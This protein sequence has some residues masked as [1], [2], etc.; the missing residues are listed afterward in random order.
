[1]MY[2]PHPSMMQEPTPVW[3]NPVV[4][5]ITVVGLLAVGTFGV[6]MGMMAAKRRTAE[7]GVEASTVNKGGLIFLTDMA[8]ARAV[9]QRDGKPIY[10]QFS[11]SWCPPCK[12]MV[13]KT[14]PDAGVQDALSGYVRLYVDI[15][16][17]R[18]LAGAYNISGV[19]TM[20]VLD[21]NGKEQKRMSG[22]LPPDMLI[23][24]LRG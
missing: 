5:A 18:S 15:D 6:A 14:F 22:G 24:F 4:I 17:Q 2:P 16:D 9:A 13:N 3:K 10:V 20:V 23:D 8:A 7:F 21:A 1:M 12:M 11:A 19:P